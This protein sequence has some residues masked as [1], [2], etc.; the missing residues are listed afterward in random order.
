MSVREAV[1]AAEKAGVG[2]IHPRTQ[3]LMID[4]LQALFEWAV[5]HEHRPDNPA[6]GLRVAAR[7]GNG[8]RPYTPEQLRTIFSA[9]HI[10]R[11]HQ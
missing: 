6:K 4:N 3:T 10:H 2:Q 9:P 7:R 8:R 5:Q 1:D 11:V